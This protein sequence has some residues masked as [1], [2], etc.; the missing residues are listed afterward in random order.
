MTYQKQMKLEI[1][2]VPV[3]KVLD[4]RHKVLWPDKSPEF[5]KVPE[6]EEARHFGL[7]YDDQIVSVISLFNTGETIRFRKF[8]TIQ[9]HQNKGL[10]SKLLQ[11]VIDDSRNRGYD[12]IWCDA[13]AD[14]MGFY[15]KFGFK[16]FSDAFMKEDIEYFKI[17]KAL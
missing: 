13:R 12:K 15:E 2:K 16:K 3:S 7:F 17:E 11:F 4:I 14:A 5:V 1:K 6:D 9:T 8:A 10:G